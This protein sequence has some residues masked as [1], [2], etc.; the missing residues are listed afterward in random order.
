MF[1][2]LSIPAE[3]LLFSHHPRSSLARSLNNN[4][5][6]IDGGKAVAAVL[7]DTQITT[8]RR[9]TRTHTSHPFYQ[10][11]LTRPL[12][13]SHPAPRSQSHWQR[14]WSKGRHYARWRPQEDA[15]YQPRVRRGP[16][17]LPFC[18]RP[19]TRLLSHHPPTPPLARSLGVNNIGA[20]AAS[21]LAAV[22]EKTQITNLGC[23]AAP[24]F[25]FLS[26]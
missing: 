3:T 6:G 2:F 7:K 20:K 16:E 9:E 26:K 8:L 13:V 4:N 15:D 10:R 17:C 22:L 23:A 19:L 14:D 24:V 18:Q 25:A 1:A 12:T 21:K 11:P 5:I